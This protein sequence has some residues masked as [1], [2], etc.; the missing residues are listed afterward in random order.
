MRDNIVQLRFVVVVGLAVVILLAT[1]YIERCMWYIL[2]ME[3]KNVP[4]HCNPIAFTSVINNE[5]HA[6][7]SDAVSVEQSCKHLMI[8]DL[9]LE[10]IN[11]SSRTARKVTIPRLS[12]TAVFFTCDEGDSFCVATGPNLKRGKSA[13]VAS[14]LVGVLPHQPLHFRA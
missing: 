4:M 11:L 12:D 5:N 1:S 9:M 3:R 7:G 6:K 2:A 14:G 8:H 13:V 10:K